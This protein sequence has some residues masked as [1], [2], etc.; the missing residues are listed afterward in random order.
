[1]SEVFVFDEDEVRVD[2]DEAD[3]VVGGEAEFDSG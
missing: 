1:V 3:F 2:F